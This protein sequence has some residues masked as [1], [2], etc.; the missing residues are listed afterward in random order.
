V[1]IR[2]LGFQSIFSSNNDKIQIYVDNVENTFVF[3]NPNKNLISIQEFEKKD[4]GE[5]LVV[6]GEEEED[7]D[8]VN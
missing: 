2:K 8:N 3:A 1:L 4:F 5:L 7:Y 6:E